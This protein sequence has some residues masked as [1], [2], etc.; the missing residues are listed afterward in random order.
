MPPKPGDKAKGAHKVLNMQEKLEPIKLS[1]QGISHA[2]IGR[3]LGV[4]RSSVSSILTVKDKVLDEIIKAT[5]MHIKH[6]GKCDSLIADIEKVLKVWTQD[7]TSHNIPLSTGIIQAKAANAMK[8]Q[9]GESSRE[10]LF[11]KKIQ[12]R[13]FIAKKDRSMPGFKV[14]KD[15]LTLLLAAN[16]AGDCKLK[17]LMIYRSGNPRALK[18]M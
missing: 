14:A 11:S 10:G 3:T 15:R 18:M 17:P 2:D 6:S 12:S 8:A 16:A 5:P 7:Q 1:E 13:T 9:R 4:S